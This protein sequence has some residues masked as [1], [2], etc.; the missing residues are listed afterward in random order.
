MSDFLEIN[1]NGE[2]LEIVLDR[3]KASKR[4]GGI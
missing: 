1:K 2:I 3:P 4:G